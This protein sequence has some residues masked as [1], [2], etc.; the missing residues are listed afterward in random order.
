MTKQAASK[1]QFVYVTYIASTPEK[2]WEALTDAQ[3]TEKYWFGFKLYSDWKVGSPFNFKR[4]DGKDHF[5][6]AIILESDP[7]RRLSYTWRPQEESVRHERP[8]RVTFELVQLENQ[9]K[10]TVIH[11]DFEEASKVFEGISGGWPKV[12]SS[13]KSLLETGRALDLS[14][15]DED[16]KRIA[17]AEARA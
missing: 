8:S 12:L 4:P 2:I 11:D 1:P 13:L 14:G 10:L 15:C 16:K 5:D 6:K 3:L 7:P 17:A 9:V